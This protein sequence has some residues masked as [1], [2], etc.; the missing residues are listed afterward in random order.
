MEQ[1]N[2]VILYEIAA[3]GVLCRV[4][5]PP[6]GYL[7]PHLPLAPLIGYRGGK[8]GSRFNRVCCFSRVVSWLDPAVQRD[9]AARLERL[10][11]VYG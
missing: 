6:A 7:F 8:K 11:V 5:L 1:Q 10:K 2:D 3:K 4:R 9:A